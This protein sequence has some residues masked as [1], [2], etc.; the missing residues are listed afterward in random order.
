[1]KKIILNLIVV[2]AMCVAMSGCK[3]FTQ[4]SSS[5]T[6]TGTP[7]EMILVCGQAEWQSELGDTLRVVFKQP[8]K[9]LVQYEPMYDVVRIMPNNFKSLT[10]K[11]RNIVSIVVDESI[12]EPSIMVE[13]DVT[14]APQIFVTIKGHD[15]ASVA[16]YVSKNK[17]NILYVLATRTALVSLWI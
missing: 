3:A 1:M 13:Y 16:E 14:A 5:E 15:N 10:K 17:E 4:L 2:V 12:A 8:V 11:H 6:S 7:Y 9:E